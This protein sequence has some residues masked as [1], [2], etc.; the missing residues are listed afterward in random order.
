MQVR[1]YDEVVNAANARIAGLS[2][3]LTGAHDKAAALEA[4]LRRAEAARGQMQVLYS[5]CSG[6]WGSMSTRCAVLSMGYLFQVHV[7]IHDIA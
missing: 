5:C 4:D 7:W 3:Q 6:A 2:Q 1:E